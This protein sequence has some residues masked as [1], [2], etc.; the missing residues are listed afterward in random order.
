MVKEKI[1]KS[2]PTDK[3]GNVVNPYLRSIKKSE[4]YLEFQK[5][6]G[7]NKAQS[8]RYINNFLKII[9]NNVKKGDKVIL[10]HFGTFYSKNIKARKGYDITNK[11]TIEIPAHR[12]F[13]FKKSK[14]IKENMK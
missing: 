9:I 5:T 4:V 8:I 7:L 6:C 10:N 13:K 12:E 11:K 2:I 14:S 3:D 1:E